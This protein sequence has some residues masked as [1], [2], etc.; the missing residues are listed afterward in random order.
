MLLSSLKTATATAHAKIILMGEHAVVYGQPAI[1]LPLSAVQV[2]TQI[3]PNSVAKV[4]VNSDFY[5]GPLFSDTSHMK[6]I[7]QMLQAVIET[8][9]LPTNFTLTINSQLPAERGM[10]SSAAVA[11]SVMRALNLYFKLALSNDQIL[12]FVNVAEKV[13]HKNPSGLDAITCSANQPVWMVRNQGIKP[14]ALDLAGYLLICDSGIRGQTAQA[15]AAVK[16]LLTRQPLTTKK[17]LTYLGSLT[18]Q[19]KA[20]LA[21]HQLKQLGAIFNEAQITLKNLAVSCPRLD[22]LIAIANKNG[23]IGTKLTGGG[24]G[25][26]FICLVETKQAAIKLA[27]ILKQNGVT[28]TWLQPL[29]HTD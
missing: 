16:D 18:H 15:I 19:A 13:T 12:T 14:V 21:N 29:E 1:A 6:G 26:C 23:A 9:E 2:T 25:G 27:A 17:H 24:R 8:F 28:Q 20:A 7:A 11:I 5:A 22:E 10:G 3:S 4:M